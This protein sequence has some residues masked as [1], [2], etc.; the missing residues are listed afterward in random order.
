M[1][2]CRLNYCLE[3]NES[4]VTAIEIGVSETG[5]HRVLGYLAGEPQF[6]TDNEAKFDVPA[7]AGLRFW[8]LSEN[9]HVLE[10]RGVQWTLAGLATNQTAPFDTSTFGV[11]D[12]ICANHL[13]EGVPTKR[14]SLRVYFPGV[15]DFNQS[16]PNSPHSGGCCRT[17]LRLNVRARYNGYGSNIY[18]KFLKRKFT[19]T[20]FGW[21]APPS[22]NGTLTHVTNWRGNTIPGGTVLPQVSRFYVERIREPFFGREARPEIYFDGDYLEFA[23]YQGQWV[24][25]RSEWDDAGDDDISN[26]KE[27]FLGSGPWVEGATSRERNIEWHYYLDFD[28]EVSFFH[29]IIG[30]ER[31]E[32]LEPYDWADF[33]GAVETLIS[34][35]STSSSDPFRAIPYPDCQLSIQWRNDALPGSTMLSG[36]A[37][38]PCVKL[39]TGVEC[40]QSPSSTP[41]GA[42]NYL[43]DDGRAEGTND[44]PLPN[45]FPPC[46]LPAACGGFGPT[47]IPHDYGCIKGDIGNSEN[48]MYPANRGDNRADIGAYAEAS[49]PLWEEGTST[50]YAN[51]C[52]SAQQ[53]TAMRSPPIHLMSSVSYDTTGQGILV[54]WSPVKRFYN[55]AFCRR[56]YESKTAGPQLI[57]CEHIA[58]KF[59]GRNVVAASAVYDSAGEYAPT[60]RDG[61]TYQFERTNPAEALKEDG[62]TRNPGHFTKAAFHTI[63]LTGPANAAVTSTLRVNDSLAPSGMLDDVARNDPHLVEHPD[64]ITLTAE[65]LSLGWHA[66]MSSGQ[67][68]TRFAEVDC[69]DHDRTTD[70]PC[71]CPP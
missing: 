20:Y 55:A 50:L 36:S 65:W 2:E 34:Q 39:V 71:G 35:F 31:E 15:F 63:I 33:A 53:G 38:G 10:F 48:G 5:F 66:Q 28:Y 22:T 7:P 70:A 4:G 52:A 26:T 69:P 12:L 43:Y 18:P 19:I 8:N 51:P 24:G 68:W 30:V 41:G 29:S 62:T 67:V 42:R 14:V 58:D 60:L 45:V 21:T 44:W 61:V 37:G 1:S 25:G 47:G 17:S 57:L 40:C 9:D 32:Y 3:A 59:T 56:V 46:D 64:D 49:L 13:S 23:A 27:F 6:S 54:T 11:Y 16:A